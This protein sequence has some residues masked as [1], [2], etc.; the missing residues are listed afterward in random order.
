MI[1]RIHGDHLCDTDAAQD[2]F[3]ADF[4]NHFAHH[5]AAGTWMR[6]M[7]GHRGG[8]IVQHHQSE[9]RLV[10]DGIHDTG[11]GRGEECG[12]PDKRKAGTVRLQM[13]DALGDTEAGAHA[14]AG[15][16]HVQRN[17]IAE[18]V[19]A[20]IPAEDGFPALHGLF[21]GIEG[22]PVRTAG[23]EHRR[24]D[25]KGRRSGL[26]N[27]RKREIQEGRGRGGNAVPG[28]FTGQRDMTGLFSE[29]PD[30]QAVLSADI[31]ERPFN[32]GI[33]F[34]DTEHFIQAGEE[35]KGFLFREGER[36]RDLQHAASAQLFPGFHD[37]SPA[38][39]AGGDALPAGRI[40]G[41]NP[42]GS[43]I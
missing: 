22:G 26:G 21:D 7:A 40:P 41:L 6:L 17:G 36:R 42:V 24:A 29:N 15:I 9:F 37:I 31:D 32:D 25:R 38:D 12:I 34:L 35:F 13:A 1:Q 10:V 43:I 20:D 39:A 3:N 5:G 14:Q 11:Q 18:R 16:H 4:F 23:A 8:G 28:V 33:Q 27:G 2:I 30:R 19:T